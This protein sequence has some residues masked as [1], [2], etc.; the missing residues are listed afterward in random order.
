GGFVDDGEGWQ[1]AAQ[2]EAFEE[3][4]AL[5]D[6][7]VPRL[8]SI[9]TDNSLLCITYCG[10]V[11]NPEQLVESSAEMRAVRLLS[12]TQ[13]EHLVS[14]IYLPRLRMATETM[15]WVQIHSGSKTWSLQPYS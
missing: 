12:P 6:S 9:D 14:P 7:L 2:R 10:R 4:G 8:V 13:A 11:T 5:T 3:V 15:S 1:T